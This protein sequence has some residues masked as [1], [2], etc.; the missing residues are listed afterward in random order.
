MD[1]E[2]IQVAAAPTRSTFSAARVLALLCL[3]VLTVVITWR[4]RTLETTLERESEEPALVDKLA[5]DFSASTLDGRT[6]SLADFRGKKKVV[7]SFWASWCGPCQLEMPGLTRFYHDNHTPSSDFEILAISIDEDFKDASDFAS[8][9]KINIPV[10]LDS[11]QKI[12]RSY[13]VDAIPAL[14]V[15]DKDGKVIYGHVGYDFALEYRLRSELGIKAK[16]AGEDSGGN[17][18]H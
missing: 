15:V 9:Q 17:T 3:A 2:T 8:A 14:F 1:A 16:S 7:V 13:D 10:L 12:A 11:K 6:V 5:P 18:G 4:A